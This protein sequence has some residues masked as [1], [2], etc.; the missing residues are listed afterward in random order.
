VLKV[1]KDVWS[2]DQEP[3][4]FLYAAKCVVKVIEDVLSV[5]RESPYF[6]YVVLHV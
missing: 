4:C 1:I 3:L 5:D 6:L 2:V